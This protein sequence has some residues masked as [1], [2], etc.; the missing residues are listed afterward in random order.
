MHATSTSVITFALLV[1]ASWRVRSKMN[2][3]TLPL[4]PASAVVAYV[5]HDVLCAIGVSQKHSNLEMS[6]F[7]EH[8]RL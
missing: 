4:I 8:H 5:H 6:K 7:T 2:D 3:F 1:F